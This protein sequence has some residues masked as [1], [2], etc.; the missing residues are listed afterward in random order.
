M[1]R[2]IPKLQFF[3]I[4][5]K[6]TKQRVKISKLHCKAEGQKKII[7]FKISGT[8]NT[9]SN[10]IALLARKTGRCIQVYPLRSFL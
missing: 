1:N 3:I 10:V 8:I 2:A 9:F 4:F 7:I 5:A 6:N